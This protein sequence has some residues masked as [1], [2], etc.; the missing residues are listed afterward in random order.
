MNAER[1]GSA[2]MGP[3][4]RDAEARVGKTSQEL[5]PFSL[6]SR[7]D[8]TMFTASPSLTVSSKKSHFDV[9]LGGEYHAS[10]RLQGLT[11]S[12]TLQLKL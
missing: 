10:D 7:F 9:K 12:L 6:N 4:R 8:R 2:L 3:E 5:P 1:S 11:T